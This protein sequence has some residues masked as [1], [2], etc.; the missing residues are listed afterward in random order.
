M[1]KIISIE[2]FR[3][4]PRWL[5]VKVT[6]EDGQFGWGE[7]T[8]EGHTEAIEGSL[9]ELIGRF[10]GYEAEYV[11]QFHS[12]RD[13]SSPTSGLNLPWTWAP[14]RLL[15]GALELNSSLGVVTLSIS[16]RLPGDWDFIE[17]ELFLCQP[18]PVLILHYGILKVCDKA[19]LLSSRWW[20]WD[21]VMCLS[22]SGDI[23]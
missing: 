1:A 7:S 11:I 22:S 6:S 15:F 13:H 18:F 12:P 21:E 8:L 4:L 16:G 10:V 20:L 9:D 5:F 2:Y 19:F 3:V 14:H 23:A 17:A